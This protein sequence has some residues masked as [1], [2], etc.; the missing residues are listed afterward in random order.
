MISP[1]RSALMLGGAAPADAHAMPDRPIQERALELL[2][3][4]LN[5][6]TA[7]FREGQWDAIQRLVE[8]RSR[9]LVVQRT[10]WGKSMVYFIATRLLRDRGA[11]PTLIVSPLLSLMR[12]QIDAA[13]RIGV[14][15]ATI[16]SANTGEWEEVKALVVRG[17]VDVL[18]VSPE[19]LAN[20][21]F[22]REVLIPLQLGV[23]L[24]VVDE[25]H[26]ISDWGHDFRPDFRRIKS[27]IA[28]MPVGVPVLATTATANDRVVEDVKAQL[29]ADV[30][31]MRGPLARTN[32]RLQ[33]I[34][35]PNAVE[36]LAWL[37]DHVPELPGSGVIYTLTVRDAERVAEWL[38]ANDVD[39]YAYYGGLEGPNREELE[40]RLLA[41][42][43]K[44]L[45]ATTALGM[46]FDKP[47]LGFVIHYQR[48]G[49][50]VHY[51]QQV[52][53]AGRA[54]SDAY[55]I[56]LGGEEDDSIT[57]Y[58]IAAASPLEAHIDAV[59]GALEESAVLPVS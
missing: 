2:R 24:F 31:V 29:G 50:V 21:A 18:L 7:E 51:Y 53:R 3:K 42:D 10:G 58:F 41:N 20:D 4:S 38:R 37:A 30:E 19:R 36:R 6:A 22:R 26:C 48:P 33:N 45:I 16:N 28:A 39:A 1:D 52:G 43:V 27:L 46:G 57:E 5:N 25:A 55:G 17:E 54:V 56:L 15:A 59:L 49:S 44:A 12:N 8:H 23:G 47:D 11:G 34:L 35:L 14:R 40:R 32:L 13:A 9:L